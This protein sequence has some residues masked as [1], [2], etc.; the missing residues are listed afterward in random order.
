MS[1]TEHTGNPFNC[2]VTRSDLFDVFL[3]VVSQVFSN[4]ESMNAL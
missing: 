1:S 3:V 2:R 4:S